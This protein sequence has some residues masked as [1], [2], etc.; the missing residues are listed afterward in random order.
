MASGLPVF[1]V[2]RDGVLND[3][4]PDPETGVPESPTRPHDV[5][6]LNGVSEALG[7]LRKFGLVVVISNQPNAAKGKSSLDQ[8]RRVHEEVERQLSAAG[9]GV[10]AYRYCFHHPDGS[11]PDL[12]RV[13]SCRKPEPG[14]IFD[15]AAELKRPDLARSWVIGD[16][17]IDIEAGRRA[18]CR[19]MLID[20]PLSSHRRSGRIEPDAR[21]A[22]LAEATAMIVDFATTSA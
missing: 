12:G 13:C 22:N 2:D 4:V 5:R 8:L 9:V 15:A 1:F 19:T 3:L 20:Q 14:L 11:D 7:L 10:D 18:G 16:S 21:A 6:L 17:D